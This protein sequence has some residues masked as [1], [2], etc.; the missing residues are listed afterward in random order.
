M[1]LLVIDDDSID[2][3]LLKRT[4]P[5]GWTLHHIEGLDQLAEAL[6]EDFDVVLCDLGLP[7]FQGLE[8]VQRAMLLL[9]EQNWLPLVVYSG[10][11]S[12]M[13]AEAC[14]H[15]GAAEYHNKDAPYTELFPKVRMAV[16]RYRFDAK[17]RKG[18]VSAIMEYARATDRAVSAISE[19][20]QTIMTEQAALAESIEKLGKNKT[21]RILGD[22][23]DPVTRKETIKEVT[24]SAPAIIV[25]LTTLLSGVGAVVSELLKSM[26]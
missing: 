7:P 8:V 23:R 24:V 13:M 1:R 11:P 17:R 16:A 26:K 5:A 20:Q 25:A 21:L 15:E 10:E 2:V 6:Q 19:N 3:A 4:L 14:A 12:E 22:L 18:V 9:D